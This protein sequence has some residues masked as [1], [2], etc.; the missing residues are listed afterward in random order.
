VTGRYPREGLG[1][2]GIAILD[3]IREREGR[4]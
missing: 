4:E 2:S 3:L 1:K